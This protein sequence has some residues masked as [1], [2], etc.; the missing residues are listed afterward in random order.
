MVATE[1][2]GG[3]DFIRLNAVLQR[4]GI[5]RSKLYAMIK[6]ETFPAPVKIGRA[7]VWP[8]S[9]ITDWQRR[10]VQGVAQ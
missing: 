8:S 9:R 7:T 6:E 10:Q 1:S 3:D 5:G 2:S 4:V